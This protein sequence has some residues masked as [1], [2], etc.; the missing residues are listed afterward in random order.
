MALFRVR[1]T[2]RCVARAT[3]EGDLP[4]PTTSLRE[5]YTSAATKA[6]TL[7]GSERRKNNKTKTRRRAIAWTVLPAI[8]VRRDQPLAIA[9]KFSGLARISHTPGFF[10]PGFG[11]GRAF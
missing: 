9:P 1:H 2:Q 6:G 4:C 5:P 7:F 11:G 8:P 10:K 3:V